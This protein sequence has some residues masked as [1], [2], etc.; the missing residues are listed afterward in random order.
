MPIVMQ[1]PFFKKNDSLELCCE[2]GKLSFP[3]ALARREYVVE[4]CAN[5]IQWRKCSICKNLENY[6]ERKESK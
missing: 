6:Y 3:D 2:G 1:C 4:Y 5:E